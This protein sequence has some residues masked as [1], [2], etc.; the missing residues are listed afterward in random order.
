MDN[1]NYEKLSKLVIAAIRVGRKENPKMKTLEKKHKNVWK[2]IKKLSGKTVKMDRIKINKKIMR[3]LKNIKNGPILRNRDEKYYV[4]ITIGESVLLIYHPE[5][6][7]LAH[8]LIREIHKKGAHVTALQE[9]S[10]SNIE[11]FEDSCPKAV[12]ELSEIM[13]RIYESIDV[14]IRILSEDDPRWKEKVDPKKV[15][16]RRGV[17]E[18]YLTQLNKMRWLVLGWPLKG[19]AKY[20]KVRYQKYKKMM[21]NSIAESFSKKT[22]ETC[23]FYEKA[24]KGKSEVRIIAKDGTNLIL[25]MKGR[26]ILIDDGCISDEDIARGDIGSNVPAGEVFCAPLETS[27]NGKIFFERIF[28]PGYGFIEGL[29]IE[30]KNGKIVDYKAKKNE[31]GFR[32]FLKENTES[33]KTTAELGIGCNRGTFFTGEILTDEKIFGTI[34]IAIGNNTGA[35]GGKNVASTHLDM[36]KDM[37]NGEMYIDKKLVMKNGKPFKK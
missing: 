37:K 6:W 11:L 18:F 14:R 21:F 28:I 20:F 4:D 35:Y 26:K 8:E 13:K 2:I 7:P 17:Q 10:E 12:E 5:S 30:F 19:A 3:F 23:K 33:T 25:K 16:L 32:K 9:S 22:K 36:I 29:W 1:K 27:A 31:S 24:L 34:H 15:R